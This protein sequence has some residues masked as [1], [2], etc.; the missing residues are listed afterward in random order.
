[1][2]QPSE[3]YEDL[4]RS[5]A[6]GLFDTTAD[7][8]ITEVND[9]FAQWTGYSREQLIG[10]PLQQLLTAGSTLFFETRYAQALQ[11]K[12]ELREV[13]LTLQVASGVTLPVLINSRIVAVGDTD[14]VIVRSAVFDSTER[15]DYERELIS[16][17]RAA[18]LSQQRLSVLHD[19]STAFAEATTDQALAEALAE[20][21]REAFA[22]ADAAVA[23]FTEE[24][25][26]RV[27]AGGHLSAALAQLWSS[28]PADDVITGTRVVTFESRAQL[29]V[30]APAAAA[31]LKSLRMEGMTVAGLRGDGAP[32]GALVLFYGRERTFDAPTIELHSTLARQASVV[33]DRLRLHREMQKLAMHDQLTGLAN[34]NLLSERLSHTLAMTERSG[35]PMALLFLDL[36]GF[37]AINDEVGHRAGDGVLQAVAARINGVVRESD[38]VGRFGGDEFLVVCEE[39]DTE[40][41]LAVAQRIQQAVSAPLGAEV[42][43]RV[44]TASIGIAVFDP[45]VSTTPSND[46]LVRLA[47]AAMY[48]AKNARTSGIVVRSIA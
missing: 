27:L 6:C 44:V 34:R 7:H 28:R 14:N 10:T 8:V 1:M 23:L 12:R 31:V 46:Q 45:A 41:A 39:A 38:I 11:L 15:Q 18:E 22:A 24:G 16:S 47:D 5:A 48:E 13:A 26:L 17:R 35:R 33:L 42:G 37:K 19:A 3:L 30:V 36:D 2:N 9:T 32:L 43:P 29:G 40:S 25:G 20:I 21:A 4:F